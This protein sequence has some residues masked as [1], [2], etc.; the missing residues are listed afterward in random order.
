MSKTDALDDEKSLNLLG[1]FLK[2]WIRY[3][4]HFVHGGDSLVVILRERGLLSTTDSVPRVVVSC[5][6]RCD[7]V[8]VVEIMLSTLYK[9]GDYFMRSMRCKHEDVRIHV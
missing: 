2:H 8:L 1:T 7:H 3:E 6:V 5:Y 4:S 9:S